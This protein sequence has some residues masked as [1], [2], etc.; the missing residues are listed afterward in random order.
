M[1]AASS[2]PSSAAGLPLPLLLTLGALTA[3]APMAIDM[4]LPA[5]PALARDLGSDIT[6]AQV[7]LT[8]C[9]L[10]LALG[11]LIWG[12]V[13]DRY[14]RKPPLLA[15][16]SLFVLASVACALAPDLHSLTLARFVQALGGCAGLVITR[17]YVRD[18]FAA[19]DA[20]RLF[21]LLI[22][23]MGLAPILAPMLGSLLLSVGSWRLV[24]AALTLFGLACLLAAA[25]QLDESLA[26]A[27][28]QSLHP[29]AV[30]RAF[31]GVAR[32]RVFLLNL[33]SGGFAQAGM[34][35]YITASPYVFIEYF[36]LTP[37]HYSWLF[38]S[39]ALGLIALSQLNRWLLRHHD[40]S[41]VQRAGN[42]LAMLAGLL[43]LANA[44]SGFGG[45]WG[46]ALPLW[47]FIAVLGMTLPNATA[48]AMAPF[49]RHA[50]TASALLGSL[51]F[52]FAAL[53][54]LAVSLL[55]DG[56]PRPMALV[57]AA[58]ATTAWLCGRWA[59]RS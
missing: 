1:S 19:R 29:L 51:Q 17:A 34:F 39:N 38:G 40:S 10:G 32:N 53:A 11:Q 2:P 43:L 49:A 6:G 59:P 9:F 28:R 50:G 42:L 37:G 22:L 41:R 33:A 5:L 25:R 3:F 44:V 46:V 27:A 35:A 47:S 18:R 7:T 13:A 48:H 45:V 57:I 16:V 58:G 55:H 23:V 4:Y 56:T 31:A 21:S 26:P 8:A 20:A 52:L 14:G 15:G 54:S 30:A 24:F 12:P 36:R